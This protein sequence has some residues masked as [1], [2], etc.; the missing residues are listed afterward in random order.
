MDTDR[1]WALGM[2]QEQFN[3]EFERKFPN[4]DVIPD[5][6]LWLSSGEPVYHGISPVNDKDFITE[7]V[8]EKAVN[9]DEP[10]KLEARIK[11]PGKFKC[12]GCHEPFDYHINRWNHEKKCQKVL[13]G[14][15]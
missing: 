5:V 1:S 2:P 13:S 12:R 14:G 6:E 7:V 8:G 10:Q 11:Q 4:A 9:D 15:T 3:V